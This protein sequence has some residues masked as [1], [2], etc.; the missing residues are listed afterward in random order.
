MPQKVVSITPQIAELA[1][2]LM[3][4][5]TSRG[6][7][8]GDRYLSTAEASRLLG[9]STAAA[10]RA[11][12]LLEHRRVISR[13]QRKGA[14]ILDYS[15]DN[16]APPLHRV[17][18]LTHPLYM[19]TEG[20]GNDHILLGMQRDLPGVHVQISFLPQGDETT[21]VQQLIGQALAADSTDGFVLVR[22]SC[23]TQRLVAG[24]GLPAVV[25]GAVYP[26]IDG[27]A[28]LDRD[29]DSVGGL[30]AEWM[31][32][33][34]HRRIAYLN[35][36]IVLPGDNTTMEAI[37]GVLAKAGCPVDSLLVR[38]LPSDSQASVADLKSLLTR[39][40][41]P[42]GFICRTHRIAENTEA[43]IVRVGGDPNKF[44][45]AVCD[46]FS[47]GKDECRFAY[48][49]PIED[50]KQQG[51]HLARLL[52]SQLDGKAGPA[53]HVVVPVKLQLPGDEA[54]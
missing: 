32:E 20:M 52:S 36:Q 49:R 25:F 3:D 54:T 29:M 1:N 6:L 21:L 31:L 14:F 12:Q 2:Q 28:S 41:P 34:G 47:G 53:Q 44:D 26:G 24:S 30:L 43:A 39:P 17:H 4:D 7:S 35:R 46:F 37:A 40:N 19:R 9:V 11:L 18:F 51:Q 8:P 45:I 38:G 13:Q 23:E 33:R 50:D 27:L 15:E 5:I 42:T 16:Q 48:P 22:V 10:N